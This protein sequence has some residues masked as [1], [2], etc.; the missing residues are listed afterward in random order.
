MIQEILLKLKQV[1]H[2]RIV[3]TKKNLIKKEIK[4]KNLNF[5]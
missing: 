5:W 1:Y 2:L 3:G 4:L